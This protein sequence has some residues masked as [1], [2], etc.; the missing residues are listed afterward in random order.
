[1]TFEDNDVVFVYGPDGLPR[2][3]RIDKI[4]RDGEIG[5][6]FDDSPGS[7]MFFVPECVFHDTE[8]DGEAA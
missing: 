3:G 5:I 6:I 1:M 2:Y 7:R 4:A 8:L